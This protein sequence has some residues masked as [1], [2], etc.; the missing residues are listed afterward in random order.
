MI[1]LEAAIRW[2]A[3]EQRRL[4]AIDRWIHDG[5]TIT[6]PIKPFVE[7]YV[8][9]TGSKD[10]QR[11]RSLEA[12]R[13]AVD[14]FERMALL[15]VFAAFEADFRATVAGMMRRAIVKLRPSQDA[16]VGA[17]TAIAEHL[18]TMDRCLRFA[19]HLEPRFSESDRNALDNLRLFR[20]HVVH[21]GFVA[22]PTEKVE[23]AAA[24][25]KRIL[26]LFE[27]SKDQ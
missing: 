19:S 20:N 5:S 13:V 26:E 22:K 8:S 2:Y 24:R 4:K 23:D 10:E 27:T 1:H 18:P 25:C 7:P 11:K 14:D 16:A 15:R 6:N 9:N 3:A 21:G 12:L 17:E